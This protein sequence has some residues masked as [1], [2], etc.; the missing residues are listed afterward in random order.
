MHLEIMELMNELVKKDLM[1]IAK[2]NI[3]TWSIVI[4][5]QNQLP[6]INSFVQETGTSF[7]ILI[8]VAYTLFKFYRA[9]IHFKWKREDRQD[10]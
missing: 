8:T 1:D 4:W 10:E 6:N 3:P 2:V 5:M 7:L 9:V